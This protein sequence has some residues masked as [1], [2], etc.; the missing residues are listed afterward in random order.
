MNDMLPPVD[1]HYLIEEDDPERL[2]GYTRALLRQVR[3]IRAGER[4]DSY[5]I[6]TIKAAAC[7]LLEAYIAASVLPCPELG[8]LIQELHTGTR[9]AESGR[10]TP[11]TCPPRQ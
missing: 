1:P 6:A 2:H 11:L 9:S 10:K 3:G 8:H 4:A 5:P 7:W